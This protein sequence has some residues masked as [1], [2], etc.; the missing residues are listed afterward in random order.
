VDNLERAALSVG[1]RQDE[2]R[3]AAA[4]RMK[5]AR[6]TMERIRTKRG[7]TAQEGKFA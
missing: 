2:D 4:A 6:H 5:A 3:N 1:L 7:K